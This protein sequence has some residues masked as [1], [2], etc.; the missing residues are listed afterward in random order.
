VFPGCVGGT[1]FGI[2]LPEDRG[3]FVNHLNFR[4]AD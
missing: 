4:N 2:E 1:G 3:D